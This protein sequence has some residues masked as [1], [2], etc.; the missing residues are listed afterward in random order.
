M[1]S[2]RLLAIAALALAVAAAAGGCLTLSYWEPFDGLCKP[3]F[4]K[5]TA[6]SAEEAWPERPDGVPVLTGEQIIEACTISATCW[7]DAPVWWTLEDRSWFLGNC[8]AAVSFAAERAIP[9][10]FLAITPWAGNERAE[11]WVPCVLDNQDDCALV[12]S[13]MTP[14]S[15]HFSCQED[16]C[17]AEKALLQVECAG[18]IATLFATD[19]TVVRDCSRAYAECDPMSRTGCTDRHF[20][21]CPAEPPLP[22]RCDG[23]IRLGCDGGCNVSY[24]DCT[25]MG[26]TC[27]TTAGGLGQCVY[28]GA[29]PDCVGQGTDVTCGGGLASACVTGRRVTVPS[30]VCP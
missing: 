13:C 19:E 26:G 14:R 12:E 16:G 30:A 7:P 4:A 5:P 15:N 9:V 6:T 22:D 11:F 25:R 20:S 27:E 1:A 23:D 18:T 17:E 3:D 24:R 10:A 8:V 28:P 21:R 29:T 2:T